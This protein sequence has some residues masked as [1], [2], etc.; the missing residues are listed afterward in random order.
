[1]IDG[2]GM[3]ARPIQDRII[4]MVSNPSAGIE[5][6]TMDLSGDVADLARNLDTADKGVTICLCRQIIRMD[7]RIVIH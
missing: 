2:G 7:L 3:T 4:V 1:M 5:F 6:R